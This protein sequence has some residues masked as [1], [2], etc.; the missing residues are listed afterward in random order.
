MPTL[1]E[2]KASSPAYAGISDA[3]FADKVYTKLYAGKMSRAEFDVRTGGSKPDYMGGGFLP[4]G[5]QRF[6]DRAMDP[7]GIKDELLGATQ[8]ARRFVTSGGSLDEASKAYTAAAER[9]RAEQEVARK[10]YGLAPE[11]VGTVLPAG[12]VK[13]AVTR[14]L[15]ALTRIRNAMGAGAVYGGAAGVG[16]SEGGVGERLIGGAY[17]AGAGAIAGPIASEVIAPVAGRV[18]RGLQH[19]ARTAGEKIRDTFGDVIPTLRRSADDRFVRALQ[20]Q[21]M[22][23]DDAA[24]EYERRQA[25]GQFGK[26]QVDVPVTPADLGPAMQRQG[27]AIA[28]IPG[29]GSAMAEEVYGARQAGQFERMNEYLRRTLAVSR[30]DYTKTSERLVKEMREAA[31]PAYKKFYDLKDARGRPV[32]YD[33][34]PVLRKSEM[35]D[36]QLSPSLARMMKKARTEFMSANVLRDTGRDM[37]NEVLLG[38]DAIMGRSPTYKLTGRR[39]DSGKQTLDDMIEQ[40]KARGQNNQ[41]RLLTELKNDLV[42]YV[43]RESQRQAVKVKSTAA[44]DRQGKKTTT[45]WDEP[46]LDAKGKPVYESLYAKARDAYGTPA[47]LKTA[48]SQGRSFMKGDADM[49]GAAYRS[50]STAEKRMFRL[51]VARESKRILGRKALGQDMISEFRKPN[52]MEVLSEV[53]SPAKYRQFMDLVEGEKIMAGSNTIIRGGSPTANKLADVED[54]NAFMTMGRVLKEKG[55]AGAAFDAIGTTIEKTLRMREADAHNLARLMFQTDR[56]KVRAEFAR[57]K[58]IY[59]PKKVEEG[60]RFIAGMFRAVIAAEAGRRVSIVPEGLALPSSF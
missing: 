54:L 25:A 27:R 48:L 32:R 53:M 41:V 23:V 15:P 5:F 9:D 17:G 7:F 34:G 33:V 45:S 26:T 22:T 57:L 24:A 39:F 1:Q 20:R 49:T 8:F 37:N 40:A 47:S 44:F 56:Q 60:Q 51:G 14:G 10:D 43:D 35:K 4:E 30:D 55:L 36:A 19:G 29:R 12:L 59:G 50:L 21:G 3:E 42:A 31:A 2:L 6:T 58:L 28:T 13:T 11:L 46:V 38:A 16:H 52:T 18:V